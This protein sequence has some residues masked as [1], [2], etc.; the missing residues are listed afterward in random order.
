MARILIDSGFWLGLCDPHD[1]WHNQAKAVTQKLTVHHWLLPWPTLYETLSTRFIK[2]SHQVEQ[3][4]A[5]LNHGKHQKI[6]DAKYRESAL[7][8]T[9]F[10]M[11][12]GRSLSLVDLVLRQMLIDEA[13][14]IK[15][16][17]TFNARDFS[18]VCQRQG[19]QFYPDFS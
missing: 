2:K 17:V 5:E 7:S 1:Q 11:R 4:M 15:A 19:I 14:H 6:D 16:I 12:Q 10:Y 8:Q 13:L 9:M 3:F 18:D